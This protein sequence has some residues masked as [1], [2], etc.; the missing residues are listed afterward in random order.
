MD[1]VHL[2][3]PGSHPFHYCRM[4]R[5]KGHGAKLLS[6]EYH[7]Q[8]HPLWELVD[9]DIEAVG[10]GRIFEF[11]PKVWI[12]KHRSEIPDWVEMIP[13]ENDR[14]PRKRFTDLDFSLNIIR[15]LRG[16][17]CDLIHAWTLFGAVWASFSGHQYVYHVTGNYDWNKPNRVEN[18]V[19]KRLYEWLARRGIK[20][21]ERVIVEPRTAKKLKQKYDGLKTRSLRHPIDTEVYKPQAAE[22]P[23][24]S[25]DVG[26][27]LFAGARH[28]WENK[29]NDYIFRALADSSVRDYH[30]V[31]VEWGADVEHSKE[32]IAELGIEDKVTWIPLMS[33]PRLTRMLN[34]ADGV[35]D[36]FKRGFGT[37]ATQTLSCGTPLIT[38]FSFD[39]ETWEESD[40]VFGN[41]D[42]PPVLEAESPEEIRRHVEEL[43]DPD[44]RLKPGQQSREWVETNYSW[45]MGIQD[46]IDV[47]SEVVNE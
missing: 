2:L 24:V 43:A 29:H 12:D 5:R 23:Y 27:L 18:P 42:R 25:E 40:S 22:S 13:S 33:R 21:A 20:N 8:S 28:S 39:R 35:F 15:R 34:A 9:T 11:Y 38:A 14:H 3:N 6:P 19:K 32:L 4:L 41:I 26:L 30:L 44:Y 17:D 16:L 10:G 1:I 45:E 37:L 36:A 7:I 31:T 47:Y 46:H